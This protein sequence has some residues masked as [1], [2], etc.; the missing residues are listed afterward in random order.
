MNISE[1]PFY[2]VQGE[3]ISSGVP[4]IFIRFT[5]CN[6]DCGKEGGT[7]KCDTRNIWANKID[8]TNQQLIH[9]I[10]EWGQFFNVVD[11]TTHLVWTGGEP[12]L[13]NNRKSFFDFMT[14]LHNNNT[15]IGINVYNEVETNGTI[16]IEDFAEKRQIYSLI[17]QINC[18]PKLENSGIPYNKRIDNGALQQIVSHPNYWFKFVVSDEKEIHEIN[19]SYVNIHKIDTAR[20]I[21]MPACDNRNDLA[22]TTRKT[23]EIS[24]KCGYRMC[25]RVHILAWDKKPGV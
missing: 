4:S 18:S 12:L 13:Q 24:K 15:N 21:L 19:E 6:L 7:W 9:N 17:S 11:G 23:I 3:G 10:N 25:T 22:E 20:V 5:G 1:L 14:Y 2:S 8:Y 16:Y